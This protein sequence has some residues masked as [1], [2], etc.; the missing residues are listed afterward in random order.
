MLILQQ[1]CSV[2]SIMTKN[3]KYDDYWSSVK[4]Y[5]EQKATS[6]SFCVCSSQHNDLHL[7]IMRHRSYGNATQRKRS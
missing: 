1:S 3:V 7:S 6:S 5:S 4:K 2:Q